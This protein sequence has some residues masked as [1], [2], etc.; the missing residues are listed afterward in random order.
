MD[1]FESRGSIWRLSAATAVDYGSPELVLEFEGQTISAAHGQSIA[2]ALTAAGIRDLHG[3]RNGEG[4]G[5]FCG[6]G[7]CQDCLVLVD[8]ELRRACMTEVTDARHIARG[9]A[10]QSPAAAASVPPIDATD[11]PVRTPDVLVV[12]GG[13]G[14][15]SAA[16][17]AAEAGAKVVLLDERAR[18]GGQYYKQPAGKT[19]IRDDRQFATGRA[20][21]ARA[22]RASVGMHNHVE[23]W[24]AFAPRDIASVS[25]DRCTIWRPR[26]LVLATGAYERA[27]PVPGWTLPGVITTGAAQTLLRS[28]G[29]LPG[30]RVLVAGNGPL[31]FQVAV[32]LARRGAD[33]VAVAE[34]APPPSHRSLAALWRMAVTP[35]LVRDGAKLLGELRRRGT[36]VL[37]AHALLGVER[38]GGSLAV[39]LGS[40]GG[41]RARTRTFAADAVCMGYGFLPSNELARALDCRHSY[42]AARGSLVPERSDTFETSIAGVFAV[43]DCCGLGGARAAM[44]E[45]LIAGMAAAAAVG[46][47]ISAELKGECMAAR[48]RLRAH[49]R[50]QD[51]LRRM[52]A[53]PRLQTELATPETLICRCECVT[54]AQIEA[55][56]ADG[57]P[58]L[59][60]IKRR[61][62]LGMGSCQGR[63][64]VPIAATL[65]AAR[66]GRALD[67]FS[68]FAPRVPV[69]P[70]GIGAL[71][72]R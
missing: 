14:G 51:G 63:S 54:L 17:A 28:Y 68:F 23:V 45:G 6:M 40:G 3:A 50:F 29:V 71:S 52:F 44:E 53:A 64:C 58:S 61:T 26:Q 35:D 67:E 43:G 48:R 25:G 42:D 8:G 55:A 66:Q 38:S 69:K 2:A 7:V 10:V 46:R 34:L 65:L 31:N 41:Y 72:R 27:V 16:A 36:P 12:G 56:L 30:R 1:W 4:R 39:C 59:G 32:E 18:P 13:A 5:L 9:P 11:V 37:Y 70:I 22:Q 49:R 21:I 60:E 62:R 47:T 24:G 19:R 20:L 33:I 15:L 57:T